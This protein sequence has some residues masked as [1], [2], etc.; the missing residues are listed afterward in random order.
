VKVANL[1]LTKLTYD[2]YLTFP[3]DGRRHELV[4]GEHFVTPAPNTKHQRLVGRLHF[5]LQSHLAAHPAGEVLLSPYDVVLSD[6][7]VVEPDLVY[8]ARENQSRIT[9]A[10]L[11]GPPD[12]AVEVVSESNRRHDEVTKRKL[13][14]RAGVREY[15]IVDPEIETVKVCRLTEGILARVAELSSE[16]GGRLES[17]LLPGF[18]MD[19]RRLFG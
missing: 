15:W 5:E 1:S 17:P 6:L 9:E 4:D 19:L 11:Q 3:N 12:L 7:D 8:V 18:A 2:D 10:N 13:Y 14:E 16:E